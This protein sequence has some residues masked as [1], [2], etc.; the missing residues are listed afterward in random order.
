MNHFKKKLECYIKYYNHLRIKKR[1][2]DLSPFK[3]R[4][5][6]LKVA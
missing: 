1:L 6:V 5:Q 3:Y 2:K 4:T